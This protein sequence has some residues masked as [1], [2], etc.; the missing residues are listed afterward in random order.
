MEN[1]ALQQ[2]LK[3]FLQEDIGAGDITSDAIFSPSEIAQASFIAKDHFLCAGLGLVAAEVFRLCNPACEVEAIADSSRVAPGEVLLTVKGPVL[4]LL[5]AE[6]VALN[7]AQRL[8]GIASLTDQFVQQVAGFDVRLVDTR[9]T[10]PGLRILEKY[11][12][13][14]GGGHN[15]RFNLTDGVLIKDNHIAA[16]SSILAA[17]KKVREAVPHTIRLEVETEDLDQVR[18]CLAA[19]VDIIMLDN[20][21]CAT[22]KQAVEIIGKNAISEASGGVNLS[23]IREIAATG[24]DI[25]SVGALTHS[26]LAKD[27]SMR[28]TTV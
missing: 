11:A 1:L 17:V 25:I 4:D 18:Q 8:C 15:H 5:K 10:T 28:L 20:M 14:V 19:G 7:L 21:D 13:R 3:S 9:K 26:A 24:V 22:M 2:L 16:C 27:I 12:V 6:R 23:N